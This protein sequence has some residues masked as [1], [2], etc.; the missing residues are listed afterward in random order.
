MRLLRLA[1]KVARRTPAATEGAHTEVELM[2]MQSWRS[3]SGVLRGDVRS[4][5]RVIGRSVT[6]RIQ[7]VLKREPIPLPFYVESITRRGVNQSKLCRNEGNMT[8]G[9]SLGGDE[10]VLARSAR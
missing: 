4:S 6:K 5:S 8:E 2:Y 10:R 9:R 3:S 7:F 1:L